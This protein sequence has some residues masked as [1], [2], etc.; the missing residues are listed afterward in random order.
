M[1]EFLIEILQIALG[2]ALYFC[3]ENFWKGLFVRTVKFYKR[4]KRRF[5][6]WRKKR[7][8]SA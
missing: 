1:I 6:N 4:I 7:K 5:K 3:L 8:K 2:I